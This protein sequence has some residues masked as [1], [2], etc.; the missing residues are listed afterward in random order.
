MNF[1]TRS[2]SCSL[3]GIL[4]YQMRSPS[5]VSGSYPDLP[6]DVEIQDNDRAYQMPVCDALEGVSVKIKFRWIIAQQIP[7]SDHSQDE[8]DEKTDG[9]MCIEFLAGI[10]SRQPFGEGKSQP[11]RLRKNL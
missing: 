2:A 7:L 8:Q 3:V 1:P 10:P 11:R 4:A 6:F 5:P 9:D